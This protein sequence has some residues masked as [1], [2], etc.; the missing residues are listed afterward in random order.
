MKETPA[1]HAGAAAYASARTEADRYRR[2]VFAA[3]RKAADT[4]AT[5][6]AEAVDLAE[7][8]A[9]LVDARAVYVAARSRYRGLRAYV[10]RW[11]G[12]PEG[13]AHG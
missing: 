9:M 8:V 11:A 12:V 4:Q 10:A 5:A 2:V 3:M 7:S 13:H 1:R 6:P